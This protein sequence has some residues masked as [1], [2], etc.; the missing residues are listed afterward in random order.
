MKLR[1]TNYLILP[2]A[3][4]SLA[5]AVD[6]YTDTTVDYAY[7]QA[8]GGNS[9][10]WPVGDINIYNNA[11]VTIDGHFRYLGNITAEAGTK[12]DSTTGE[13]RI[14]PSN[15]GT[16]PPGTLLE[17]RFGG[18]QVTELYYDYTEDSRLL[19]SSF[20]LTSYAKYAV[21]SGGSILTTVGLDR[22]Y[23]NFVLNDGATIEAGNTTTLTL[24]NVT[25]DLTTYS[26]GAG[27]YE[28][29]QDGSNWS[30]DLSQVING[31]GT[32]EG[33]MTLVLSDAMVDA[34]FDSSYPNGTLTLTTG[35][36]GELAFD[37]L[38]IKNASGNI[39]WDY[40]GIG[41]NTA[42]YTIPEP[43]TSRLS[44]LAVACLVSRPRR[45]RS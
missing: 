44:L 39:T 25:M 7:R 40:T 38:S 1:K 30:L 28:L 35:E 12:I 5:Q 2:L 29:T 8:N 26:Q 36:G 17:H 3:V 27:G 23:S 11:T 34:I 6:F 32:F 42:T 14:V 31:G 13:F 45:V 19:G 9:A 16:N 33:D 43:C 15:V 24:K 41:G 37:R 4:M 10:W 21:L 18:A 20:T 22:S